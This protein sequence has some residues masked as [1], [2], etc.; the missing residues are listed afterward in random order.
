MP[1]LKTVGCDCPE[2]GP[3]PCDAG[4]FCGF[5]YA[6]DDGG[7]VSTAFDVTGQFITDH[8]LSFDFATGPEPT[9]SW[10]FEIT[11]DGVSVFSSGCILFGSSGTVIAVP[12][13]TTEIGLIVTDC[14]GIEIGGWVVYLE[15]IQNPP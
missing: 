11:L 15:C 14:S 6:T 8:D 7:P 12:A 2:C 3:T 5:A 1:W 4:C 9:A 10:N 13:G